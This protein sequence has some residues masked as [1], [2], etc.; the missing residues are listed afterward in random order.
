MLGAEAFKKSPKELM[1]MWCSMAQGGL[2]GWLRY[3]GVG[4]RGILCGF[5][6]LT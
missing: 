2:G 6:R 3:L 5:D 4:G 1:D